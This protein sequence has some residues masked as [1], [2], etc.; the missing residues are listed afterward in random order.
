VVLAVEVL[1]TLLTIPAE[2]ET[3]LQLPRPKEI[4]AA[5]DFTITAVE[6]A[7]VVVLVLLV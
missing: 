2:V 4:M 3:H 5:T 1:Q 6:V 7:V